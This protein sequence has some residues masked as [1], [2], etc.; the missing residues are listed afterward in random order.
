MRI[1]LEDLNSLDL[2]LT[3]SCG[4]V[5]RWRKL[6]NSW[7]GMVDD[8]LLKLQLENNYL[9]IQSSKPIH[10][11]RVREFFRFDDRLDIIIKKLNRNK[12]FKTISSSIKGLRF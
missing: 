2:D 10:E 7:I 9:N 5:F 3:F 12:E 8:V 1:K 11:S 6:E 4:Q